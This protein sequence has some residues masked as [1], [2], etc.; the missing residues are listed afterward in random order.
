MVEF[1][2]E[3]GELHTLIYRKIRRCHC[4][5]YLTAKKTVSVKSEFGGYSLLKA[6]FSDGDV[7]DADGD[8][9]R[10][11][12]LETYRWYQELPDSGPAHD[13]WKRFEADYSEPVYADTLAFQRM[14]KQRRIAFHPSKV[15]LIRIMAKQ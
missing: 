1:E 14:L 6:L 7:R 13:S 15:G 8:E 4:G 10:M 5:R 3:C 12:D 2:C 9:A 11:R